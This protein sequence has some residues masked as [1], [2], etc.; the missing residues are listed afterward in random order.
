MVNVA[1]RCLLAQLVLISTRALFI[2]PD[3]FQII[4]S[5]HFFFF[6]NNC[7]PF[8]GKEPSSHKRAV[9]P[10]QKLLIYLSPCYLIV[11]SV[12]AYLL[13]LSFYFPFICESILLN[14]FFVPKRA[15]EPK[16]LARQKRAKGPK[17][18]G[19]AKTKTINFFFTMLSASFFVSS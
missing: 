16:E 1:R 6:L 7:D 3:H 10:K 9:R 14:F 4:I 15:I 17:K 18:S 5:I 13:S 11:C 19:S 8:Q 2:F 12:S